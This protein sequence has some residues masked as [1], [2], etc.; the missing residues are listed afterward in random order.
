MQSHKRTASII[1]PGRG[2]AVQGFT[3]IEA[4]VAMVLVA[5]TGMALFSWLNSN[6]ITLNRV[7]ES[8]R[9]NAATL[10]AMEYMYNIN[11]MQTPQGQANL[12]AYSITWRAE[13]ST[14]PREGAGYPQGPSRYQFAMFDTLV[15]LKTPS[16][17]PWFSFALKQVGYKKVRLLTGEQ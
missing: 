5:T 3:L 1:G 8:N 4:L 6:I 13:P 2:H 12:G 11:P 14:E 17:E 15:E 16:G 10:N 9:E 7:Q